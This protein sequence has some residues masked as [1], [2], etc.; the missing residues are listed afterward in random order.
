MNPTL[1]CRLIARWRHRFVLL[2]VRA[3]IQPVDPQSAG[4][5]LSDPQVAADLV[6]ANDSCILNVVKS[7][8]DCRYDPAFMVNQT[9]RSH[10]SHWCSDNDWSCFCFS[11]CQVKKYSE[12]ITDDAAQKLWDLSL[13][14][15][16]IELPS[17]ED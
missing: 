4:L 5:L 12:N 8:A 15:T 2:R 13:K 17:E 9:F 3:L 6:T 16:K 7:T 14:M 10:C 1:Y 11:D